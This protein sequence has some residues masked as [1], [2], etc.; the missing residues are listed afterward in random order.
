MYIIKEQPEDFIVRERT[1][2]AVGKEGEYTLFLLKK[3]NY[4]TLRAIEQIAAC[5]HIPVKRIGIAG[6]KDK[7][8]ITEQH[9][10]IFHA[11]AQKLRLKD[12]TLT[13]VG[14]STGPISLGDLEGNEF[15]IKIR[16]VSREELTV[17][18][19]NSKALQVPNYFGEQRFSGR[20]A[21]I[22]KLLV[23]RK[24]AEAVQEI[25]ATGS[26]YVREKDDPVA[27][28]RN[29]PRRL[30]KFYVH[31]YQSMLW[32]AVAA[33]AIQQKITVNEVPIIGFGA[34]KDGKT[35]HLAEALMKEEHITFRD[36][37]IRQIPELS[38]E[39]GDRRLFMD[40][41]DFQY[42]VSRG[43]ITLQFFLGKGSYATTFIHELF[44]PK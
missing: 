37:I 9:I 27:A 6:N 2:I 14:K 18:K 38:A 12:I 31:A 5:F 34:R 44:Q 15:V 3:K 30:L 25:K 26:E 29:V 20:N 21:Y 1:S 22:G 35:D 4:T 13:P 43:T 11:P 19:K 24:F 8:A 33:E 32:N 10:S 36:F 28:L 42:R 41:K 40:V 23:Q 16:N 39:G 7:R 17:F